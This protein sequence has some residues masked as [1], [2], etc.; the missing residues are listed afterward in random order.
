MLLRNDR[1]LGAATGIPEHR[2]RETWTGH[3]GELIVRG[4]ALAAAACAL[5]ACT[6][7]AVTAGS[8]Q[9][10]TTEAPTVPA[11]QTISATGGFGTAPAAAWPTYGQNAGRTGVARGLATAG[12]LHR[13]W[14]A[15]LDGAV[16]AQPLVVDGEVIAATENDTVY[17]LN[18][19]TG[20]VIWRNHLATPVPQ[21]ALPCGDINPLGITGTPVYDRADGLVYVIAETRVSYRGHIYYHELFGLGW[22]GG[23]VFVRRII[24][25]SGHDYAHQQR[26]GLALDKGRVVIAFGGLAGDCD[27]YIGTVAA[28]SQL[29]SGPIAEW[30]VPTSREGGIW[31]IGGPVVGPDGDLWVSVGNGASGPGDPYDGSDSVTR[32]TLRPGN[33]LLRN[34]YFAPRTWPTDNTSDLDLGSTQP[35]LAA[36][37]ATFIL[38]KSGTGYLL[39][40]PSMGGIGRQRAS[41]PICPAYGAG[42]VNGDTVYEPCSTGGLA[43][44]A[45]DVARGT[46]R[47]LWHGPSNAHGSASIGGGAVW[48][49]DSDDGILYELS[50][51]TGR[52]RHQISLGSPLPRFSSVSL[53]GDAAFV[54]TM[55]G[56]VAVAG[57]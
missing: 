6:G 8:A 32:L 42:A 30:R 52:V 53:A 18:A 50:P 51:A 36:R 13:K 7:T 47:V 45:V 10:G 29:G 2:I 26:P 11:E 21:S 5:A 17:G 31:A 48:V 49:P 41:R 12:A 4:T 19:A 39:Y 57:A 54:G 55:N 15:T 56:V 27:Q 44:I 20:A 38:G 23:H 9:G 35:V 37:N 22:R 1:L 3:R 25:L 14:T 40:T 46:I 34:N 16:Y 24:P 43:A 33:Q 28:V